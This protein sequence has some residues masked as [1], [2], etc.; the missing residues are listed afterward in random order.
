MLRSVR[1]CHQTGRTLR[2]WNGVSA[3]FTQGGG[4]NIVD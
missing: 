2:G 3:T 1:H 4:E